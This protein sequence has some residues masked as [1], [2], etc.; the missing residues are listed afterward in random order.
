MDYRIHET[1][2]LIDRDFSLSP[3]IEK[4]AEIAN[5]SASRLNHLFKEEMG[6]TIRQYVKTKRLETARDL[7]Q[8]TNLRIKEICFRIGIS[9]STHFVRDFKKFS[10]LYPKGYRTAFR[11]KIMETPRSDEIYSR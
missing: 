2:S 3:N 7:L 1:L 4:L 6:L 8:E 10:G 9:D 11:N 5:L